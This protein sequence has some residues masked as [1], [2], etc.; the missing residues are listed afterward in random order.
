MLAGVVQVGVPEKIT[1]NLQVCT[2]CMS[3]LLRIRSYF[4]GQDKYGNL[5]SCNTI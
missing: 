4:P 1:N 5:V 2:E 3:R